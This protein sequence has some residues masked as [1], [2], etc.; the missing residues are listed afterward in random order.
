[1]LTLGCEFREDTAVHSAPNSSV[2]TGEGGVNAFTALRHTIQE[3]RLQA[4]INPLIRLLAIFEAAVDHLQG[5]AKVMAS[6]SAGLVM[7][8]T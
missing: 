7:C 4:V 5:E 8:G 1:M 3:Q 6:L 2:Q